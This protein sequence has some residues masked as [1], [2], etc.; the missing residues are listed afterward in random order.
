MRGIVGDQMLKLA[1]ARANA[2][3]RSS[4]VNVVLLCLKERD[5]ETEPQANLS[6]WSINQQREGSVQ[7]STPIPQNISVKKE[8]IDVTT[9][10][11][12]H[13]PKVLPQKRKMVDTHSGP[14][15]SFK[16]H[17]TTERSIGSKTEVISLLI[18]LFF[19]GCKATFLHFIL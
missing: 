1:V 3:V 5:R 10:N 15:S 2:Q 11:G 18:Y 8:P 6:L 12:S 4:S 9:C 19:K 14:V 13:P 16:V 7:T 17:P